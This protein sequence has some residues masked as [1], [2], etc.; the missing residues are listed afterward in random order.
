MLAEPASQQ[1]VGLREK[2]AVF[3]F[4]WFPRK[5]WNAVLR[6]L[7]WDRIEVP[8]LAGW[9]FHDLRHCCASWLVMADVPLTKVAKILGHSALQTTQR[10]AHLADSTLVDAMDRIQYGSPK[11]G[12][13]TP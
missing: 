8:R 9:R 4:E 13:N 5:Q 6:R 12:V 1:Y 7:G 11:V 2:G 3:G 10:Y